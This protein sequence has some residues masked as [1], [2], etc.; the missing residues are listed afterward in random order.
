MG[1][2]IL[3]GGYGV[4]HPA[5]PAE[6]PSLEAALARLKGA[7]HRSFELAA[8]PPHG[9]RGGSPGAKSDQAVVWMPS[10]RGPI[11]P[12]RRVASGLLQPFDT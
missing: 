3:L 5:P 2:S 12:G 4:R 9:A 11:R 10:C 7:P 8:S 6:R 1:G